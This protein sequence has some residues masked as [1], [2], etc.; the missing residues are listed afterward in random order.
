VSGLLCAQMKEPAADLA[1]AVAI[2]S[3]FY[4]VEVPRDLAVIGEVGDLTDHTTMTS[5]YCLLSL[6][7]TLHLHV[8]AG[9]PADLPS[10]H[11]LAHQARPLP[12]LP[13]TCKHLPLAD[14]S[15]WWSERGQ[16]PGPAPS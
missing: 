16:V 1:I 11:V 10:V 15:G 3:S 5:L 12:G 9:F 2:T 4:N 7:S 8:P 13:L 14:R 6:H